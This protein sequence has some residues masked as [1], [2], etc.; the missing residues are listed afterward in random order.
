MGLPTRR[1]RGLAPAPSIVQTG[2]MYPGFE[3][4]GSLPATG[5][6]PIRAVPDEV[7]Y[8]SGRNVGER[9]M[10]LPEGLVR[11]LQRVELLAPDARDAFEAAGRWRAL[12]IELDQVNSTLANVAR[13]ASIEALSSLGVV[14]ES[15]ATCGQRRLEP[16]KRFKDFVTMYVSGITRAEADAV[17]AL[18]SRVHGGEFLHIDG[19]TPWLGTGADQYQDMLAI[20]MRQVIVIAAVNWLRKQVPTPRGQAATGG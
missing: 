17:Y 16:T 10:V 9:D 11:D 7:Y 1:E 15:C 20:T 13:V 14:G 3:R 5:G 6:P 4:T 19:P 2:Y 12:S 18:R 8:G